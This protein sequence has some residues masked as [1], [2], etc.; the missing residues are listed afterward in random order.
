M[1]SGCHRSPFTLSTTFKGDLVDSFLRV[2]CG[3]GIR[4]AHEKPKR[5]P[6]EC[7]L[8]FDTVNK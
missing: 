4:A 3:R 7:N 2:R 1:L 5:E 6:S 8:C